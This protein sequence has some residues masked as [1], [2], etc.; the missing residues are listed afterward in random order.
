MQLGSKENKEPLQQF[1]KKHVS[2]DTVWSLWGKKKVT[3]DPA[4]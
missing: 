3:W 4:A 2:L 1:G